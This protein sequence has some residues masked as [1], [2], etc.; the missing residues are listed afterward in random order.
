MIS[1]EALKIQRRRV[2]NLREVLIPGA[3]HCVQ[4]ER[5]RQTTDAILEFLNKIRAENN[6][7]R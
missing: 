7:T 1:P 6:I 3:G 4:Q 2:P 5:P